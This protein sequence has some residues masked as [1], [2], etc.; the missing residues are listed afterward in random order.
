M[1]NDEDMTLAPA[2]PTM[3]PN[4]SIKTIKGET[5]VA[6]EQYTNY[7]IQGTSKEDQTGMDNL[8]P[9]DVFN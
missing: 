7:N 9:H 5:F 4:S 6:A 2:A 1:S 3:F 8:H